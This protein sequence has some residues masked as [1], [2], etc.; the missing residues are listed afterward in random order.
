M[1]EVLIRCCSVACVGTG[2]FSG[3]LLTA[4]AIAQA[5]E[6]QGSRAVF[7]PASRAGSMAAT[8]TVPAMRDSTFEECH[9]RLELASR[10]D[11]V[12]NRW[13]VFEGGSDLNDPVEYAMSALLL[14][15]VAPKAIVVCLDASHDPTMGDLLLA[16]AVHHYLCMVPGVHP[17][18]VAAVSVNSRGATASQ[19]AR[20]RAVVKSSGF[21][22]VDCDDQDSMLDHV[23][24]LLNR[25]GANR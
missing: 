15:T 3:E 2:G 5:C 4:S 1:G 25:L 6:S 11:G 9:R 17:T 21:H 19:L 16:D 10:G 23:V 12:Q 7:V 20:A 22:A 24:P 8:S 13:T 18:P 14:R